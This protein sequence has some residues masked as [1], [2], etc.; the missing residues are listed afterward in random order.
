MS[1]SKEAL[2]LA[3]SLL[4]AYRG[5]SDGGSTDFFQA[6]ELIKSLS[7]RVA[8]L[9]AQLEYAQAHLTPS[10]FFCTSP[11]V[12]AVSDGAYVIHTVGGGGDGT[13]Q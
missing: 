3:E 7:A 2:R 9:E 6:A 11:L 13:T 8:T 12:Q 4:T 1:N 10:T 5:H